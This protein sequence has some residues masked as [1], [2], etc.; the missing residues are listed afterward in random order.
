[1]RRRLVIVLAVA[2]LVGLL[3]SLLV[4]RVIAQATARPAAEADHIV[5]AIVNMGLAE[6][7]TERHVKL[8]AWPRPSVPPGAVRSLDQ[9][10]GRVVRSSIIAGEPLLDGKLAPA[11]AG[12]GG[13]MPMLV[14]EGRRG[15]T[16]RVD[17]AI[18]E[19]GF[20]LPNSRV[21]VLV[22]MA[23]EPTAQERIAKVILQD[24]LV[25]AAGQT[26]EIRDNKPVQVTTVTLALTPDETERLAL[27]Q[28]TGR[29]LLA[30]RNLRDKA[31]VKTAGVTPALLLGQAAAAPAPRMA[32]ARPSAAPSRPGPEAHAVAIMRA[33]KVSE[34]R[35]IR[36]GSQR[37]LE[38]V[39]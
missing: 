30:T 19:T 13:I 5:V 34:Q 10:L 14:P 35:F 9:A 2:S 33:D 26:V 37:W 18:K 11:L 23:R 39:K 36:D 17:D 21:D 31:I 6:T 29:L 7:V 22:S 38:Q 20:V 24:V 15:V 27:A 12:R 3:A 4:Y 16:I 8:V 32:A 28:T 25:L 1:M